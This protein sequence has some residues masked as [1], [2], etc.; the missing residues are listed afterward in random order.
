MRVDRIKYGIDWEKFVVGSS[1]FIPCIHTEAC[2][3]K[4]KQTTKDL[5][6]RVVMKVVIQDGIRGL[7]IWR[8]K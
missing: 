8:T 7:R 1:F 3:Q 6:M 4:V 5:R 2:K